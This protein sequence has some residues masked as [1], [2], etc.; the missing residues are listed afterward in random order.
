MLCIERPQ[1]I[2][3]SE[4]NIKKINTTKQANAFETYARTYNNLEILNSFN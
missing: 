1:N 2:F 4:S 3:L